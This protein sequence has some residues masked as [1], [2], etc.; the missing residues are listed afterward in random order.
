MKTDRDA[1]LD[2]LET[3]LAFQDP[4]SVIDQATDVRLR[5]AHAAAWERARAQVAAARGEG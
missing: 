4:D 3:L 5:E 1:L 2:T